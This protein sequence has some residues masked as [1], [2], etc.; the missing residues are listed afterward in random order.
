MVFPKGVYN[1]RKSNMNNYES[2]TVTKYASASYVE[3][4]CILN[5]VRE[6]VP[7]SIFRLQIKG[8]E[9]V[10]Q[11]KKILK[12]GPIKRANAFF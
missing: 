5:Y 12:F 10:T 4:L 8:T 1:K 6:S 3:I 9:V 11:N 2:L 7:G